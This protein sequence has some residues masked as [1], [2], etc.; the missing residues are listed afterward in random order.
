MSE[1]SE[2]RKVKGIAIIGVAGKFPGAASALAYWRNL[3]A[4]VESITFATDEEL[5]SA[6]VPPELSQRSDYVRAGG[7]VSDADFFDASFFGLSAR[8]SE[9]LDP[10]HR[11]FL[12]C[13]WD[14]FEDAGYDPLRYSGEVGVF[15]GAG[16][17]T[18][19]MAN[20]FAN[21]AVLEAAGGYQLMLGN[22]KDFL[23]TR[24]AYKLNL[25]GPAVSIQTACSTSLVAV[26]AAFESLQRGECEMAVAGGVSIYFPQNAGY[27]YMS[28]MIL[29]ADGHCR[30]FDAESGGTVPGRGAGAVLLKPLDAAITD[31]DHIYAVIKGA[32]IN[33]DGA[34]KVGY[35]APSVEG[36]R[37]VIA[38]SMQMAGFA[39]ETVHYVEAHGT[40][41]DLGDPIEV[42][43]LN[44]AFASSTESRPYCALGSVKTNIGHLD[45]AAGVAGLIK[46]SLV[47]RSRLI[48]PTLHYER[49]NPLIP[50][51][52]GPFYVNNTLVKY[53]TPQ[54]FRAGVSSFGI[55]G[56]N[57]H[58]SL[59]EAPLPKQSH[60]GRPQLFLLSARSETA[61]AARA[62]SLAAHLAENSDQSI[63][64]V[65]WT[66]QQGRHPFRHRRAF[67]VSTSETAREILEDIESPHLR[68][69]MTDAKEREVVFVFPGQGSQFVNMGLGLYESS[70][71][72]RQT[73][74]LCCNMLE[75]FLGLDLRKILYPGLET[76]AASDMLLAE[77]WLTQPALF[78]I[79]Y[80]AAQLWISCGLQPAA[81]LGHSV[82]EYV[83]ACLADIFTL[84]DALKL[85]A[86]RGKLTYSLP[87]GAMLAVSMSEQQLSELL[88]QG[89]SIAAVNSASQCVASGPAN[90]ITELE[91]ALHSRGIR[92]TRLRTSHAFHSSMLDPILAEF[93]AAVE[94]TDRQGPARAILSNVTGTWMT[95]EEATDAAY[96]G[97][98]LRHAVRFADCS[99]VIAQNPQWI[100]VE[101]GPGN[102]LNSLM[103]Q[104]AMPHSGKLLLSSMAT[105]SATQSDYHVWLN[106]LARL[107]L[108]GAV[109]D[110]Q[111]VHAPNMPRRV[112]LPGYPFERQR[113][114]VNAEATTP[115]SRAGSKEFLPQKKL[116]ISDWFYVPTWRR[117]SPLEPSPA[118][119]VPENNVW[120]VLADAH[121]L[122][123]AKIAESLSRI[124]PIVLVSTSDIF[125]EHSQN[126]F[127]L[128]PSDREHWDQLLGLLIGRQQWPERV[129]HTLNMSPGPD[130]TGLSTGLNRGFFSLMAIVQAI[131][132]V[133]S[134]RSVK[135]QVVITGAFSIAGEPVKQTLA[136]SLS[137]FARMLPSESPNVECTLI[138]SDPSDETLIR[139]L[140]GA[141]SS[142]I[143]VLRK[144]TRWTQA[145]DAI[146]FSEEQAS[147]S[148]DL[149]HGI[150][151]GVYLVSGG[152]GGLGL[153]FAE[154]LVQLGATR[155]VLTSRSEFPDVDQWSSLATDP[156]TSPA[157][158]ASLQSLL[159]IK[160]AGGTIHI[161]RAD[162]ADIAG[163]REVVSWC[164]QQPDGLRGI[165]HAAGVPSR[166]MLLAKTRDEAESVFRSK[167][168]G[169]EW[170]EEA[171]QSEPLDFVLLC[172]SI[173][174]IVPSPGLTDYSSANAFLDAFAAKHDSL[175]GTRVISVNWDTWAEVG[176]AANIADKSSLTHTAQLSKEHDAPHAILPTQGA[177]V[178]QRVLAFPASQVVISTRD[179]NLLTAYIHNQIAAAREGEHTQA[180]RAGSLHP[181][182]ELSQAYVEPVD[183]T[184]RTVSDIWSELFAIEK[185]GRHDNFFELGGHS[186]L[187]TQAVARIRLRFGIDLPLRTVFEAPTPA[188]LA[189]LLR[190]IP[191]ASGNLNSS[192]MLD[193]EREEIEL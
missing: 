109:I 164:T 138:D 121:S 106:E 151:C 177:D 141:N 116:S 190:A 105:H 168:Q 97:R 181:R 63:A 120:L 157:R 40:G 1:S 31:R 165:I 71:V 178:F 36:Q 35:S 4:G 99:A 23:A 129:I 79:E 16:M 146:S 148:T 94:A 145:F 155:I 171:L 125:E 160:A 75:P 169:T 57:A 10:Q 25:R 88:P 28:G 173:S 153:V 55:G 188:E 86:L 29:S 174:A 45:A 113:Y 69:G 137:G 48:P 66:L 54:L 18:Y 182:P 50:F 144:G 130:D 61:L 112:P 24:V 2:Q 192:P 67:V 124:A 41:T 184:E 59:E 70:E 19:G 101:V 179:L 30:A 73:V 52:K 139:E 17:N 12:E 74:D 119:P 127:S 81:M 176:M 11:V 27:L 39:P 142:E 158:A 172:S 33:N 126:H 76:A 37:R 122:E 117:S 13:A 132:N 87:A 123:A 147:R 65:A 5:A 26:Q 150:R 82:G 84:Q 34:S 102:T 156:E 9:I 161:M 152:L 6:G 62:A 193:T 58:V 89:V 46:A 183:D 185:I 72:F 51:E 118:P 64:D 189:N 90:S 159:R 47:L 85:V 96:W 80:A 44:E 91:Q 43:A 187:G 107:W 38:K 21:A 154:R 191:W 128:S 115:L 111:A 98:H 136:A 135:M 42:T 53:D 14:V 3:C 108:A 32:A 167:I 180:P 103:R 22:D 93:V 140:S 143:V 175:N 186:L 56:T 162:V 78:V 83:A 60:D 114:W 8:E 15:A 134:T 20:L 95:N 7:V 149:Q 92:S 100:V 133:S 163:M 170:I 166:S 131:G 104:Q 77:T 110:W 68:S 49:P